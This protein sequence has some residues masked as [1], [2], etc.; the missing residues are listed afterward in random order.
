MFKSFQPGEQKFY[1]GEINKLFEGGF[2]VAI[3]GPKSAANSVFPQGPKEEGK[4]KEE[5]EK[6]DSEESEDADKDEAYHPFN[7]K[8]TASLA[9][10]MKQTLLRGGPGALMRVHVNQAQDDHREFEAVID[11][12]DSCESG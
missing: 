2:A 8:L 11:G 4:A 7:T 5:Q 3:E 9:T 10:T 6:V 1:L 12:L